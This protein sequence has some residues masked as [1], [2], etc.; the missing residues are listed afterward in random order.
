MMGSDIYRKLMEHL[1]NVGTGYP[2]YD[3]FIEVLKKNITPEEAA[4]A[5]GLPTRLPPLE[6]EAVDLIAR[7]LQRPL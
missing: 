3:E 1:G 7:R 4:I 6:V 2:Q 5:L